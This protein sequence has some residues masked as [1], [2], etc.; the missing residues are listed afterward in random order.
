MVL[1][2]MLMV[3]QHQESE[4][5]ISVGG[6]KYCSTDPKTVEDV[7]RYTKETSTEH[8]YG[9]HNHTNIYTVTQFFF[10]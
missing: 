5:E 6:G 2:N 8:T 4:I 7:Y 9:L 3:F 1:I 10:L